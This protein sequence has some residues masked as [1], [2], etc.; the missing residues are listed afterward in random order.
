MSNRNER[1]ELQRNFQSQGFPMVQN[2]LAALLL[3]IAF[4]ALGC[5]QSTTPTPAIIA[6]QRALYKPKGGIDVVVEGPEVVFSYTE[7]TPVVMPLAKVHLGKGTLI[8]KGRAKFSGT[9]IADLGVISLYGFA[10]DGIK[11]FFQTGLVEVD[12]EAGTYTATMEF[13]RGVDGIDGKSKMTK[14]EISTLVMESKPKAG[15]PMPAWKDVII[16]TGEV[17]VS[18]APENKSATPP[19]AAGSGPENAPSS[20]S[21]QPAGMSEE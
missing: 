13:P 1:F 6:K 17:E 11:I 20:S 5:S 8:Y 16:A 19:A 9:T 10:P 21:G 3:S 12:Q 7:M 2:L 18:P 15:K 14:I 4:C